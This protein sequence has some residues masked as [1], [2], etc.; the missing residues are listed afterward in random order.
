MEIFQ[1]PPCG[2]VCESEERFGLENIGH[3]ETR[4]TTKTDI[5]TFLENK[6]LFARTIYIRLLVYLKAI[7]SA[8]QK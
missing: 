7:Y 5:L 6:S 8:V 1:I 4:P 3:F 2:F